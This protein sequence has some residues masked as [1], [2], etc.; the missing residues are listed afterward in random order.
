MIEAYTR[1]LDFGT[2]SLRSRLVNT[3][4][5]DEIASDVYN[6]RYGNLE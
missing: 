3:K 1:G 6:N 5:R 2:N 4:N